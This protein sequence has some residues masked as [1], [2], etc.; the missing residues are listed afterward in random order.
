MAERGGFEFQKAVIMYYLKC[1]RVLIFPRFSYQLL[2]S[3]ISIF[4]SFHPQIHTPKKSKSAREI[5][6]YSSAYHKK[7]VTA[8]TPKNGH[9]KR[10]R[11][12]SASLLCD[13]TIFNYLRLRL[14][15]YYSIL[16]CVLP[17]SN[18]RTFVTRIYVFQGC[19]DVSVS[20]YLRDL[21]DFH[22]S[23]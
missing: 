5:P 8:P 15:Y 17:V 13:S 14:R 21:L 18:M 7:E 12:L 3:A 2:L 16:C 23:V 6:G 20:E 11:P 22:S 9:N 4:Y 10:A 19:I 1:L